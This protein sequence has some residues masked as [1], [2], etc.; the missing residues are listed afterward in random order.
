MKNKKAKNRFK[1][2]GVTGFLIVLLFN[3][4]LGVNL[5]DQNKIKMSNLEALACFSV[6]VD[7]S[8]VWDCCAPWDPLCLP[9]EEIWIYGTIKIGRAHV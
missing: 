9:L 5:N 1:I 7:G 8:Y 6:E 3:I 4:N 2:F